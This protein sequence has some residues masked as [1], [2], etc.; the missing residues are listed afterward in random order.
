MTNRSAT[1]LLSPVELTALCRVADGRTTDLKS[2]HLQLLFAMGLAA[3]DKNGG[4]ILTIDGQQR[5][6]ASHAR[7]TNDP[8]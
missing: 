3:L 2:D 6:R 4:A 1:A 8:H 7:Q 5:L